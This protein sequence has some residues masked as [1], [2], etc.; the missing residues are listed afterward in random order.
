[1]LKRHDAPAG[2]LEQA[3]SV[4]GTAAKLRF[5]PQ[6]DEEPVYGWDTLVR[7]KHLL[8]E[9]LSKTAIAERLGVSRRLIYHL[10]ETKQLDR[11]LGEPQ[12]R[13]TRTP[14]PT[15]LEPRHDERAAADSL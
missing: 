13:R 3:E 2:G 15:K 9:G 12:P 8:D 14:P 6:L 4:A 7:L 11:E 1:M 5:S 10:I